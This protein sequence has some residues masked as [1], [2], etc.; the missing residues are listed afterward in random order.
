MA[1]S[2][3]LSKSVL[4][5][6]SSLMLMAP[7]FSG[8]AS[9]S[10][11][12]DSATD[13]DALVDNEPSDDPGTNEAP[14]EEPDTLTNAESTLDEPVAVGDK[15]QASMD[16]N[17]RGGPSGSDAILSVVP[18][19]SEVTV[20][21]AAPSGGWYRVRFGEQTGWASG[22]FLEKP[23]SDADDGSPDDPAAG[24]DST[25]LTLEGLSPDD[26]GL[27]DSLSTQ[28]VG[29]TK[30][31]GR[32]MEWVKV[33]MPY[34][35]GV[36]GGHDAICGGTCRR[37][38][39]ANKGKWNKY[40]S[41]CSGLVSYAWGLSAPGLTTSYFAPFKRNKSHGIGIKSLKAGDALNSVPSHH[42]M[43]FAGWANKAHTVATII[44]ESNCNKVAKKMNLKV[45][46][47]GKYLYFSWNNRNFLPI[48]VGKKK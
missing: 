36:N 31:V 5:T 14:P 9:D 32:A 39:A 16:L 8:C 4:I 47:N 46:R 26:D 48:R 18:E 22:L 15:L 2:K 43:L 38:G 45:K 17:L 7:L 34:C 23:G 37:H 41:D 12:D 13:E 40:R 27:Q 25:D 6:A 28:A 42:I 35:G 19:E 10:Q 33:K 24:D 21:D 30:A 20:E 1:L 29:G 3:V 11:G 44:Q